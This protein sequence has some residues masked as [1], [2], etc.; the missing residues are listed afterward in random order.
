VEAGGV[1]VVGRGARRLRRPQGHGAATL[2]AAEVDHALAALAGDLRLPPVAQ[3]PEQ[4]AVEREAALQVGDDEIE[5]VDQP[6]VKWL[7]TSKNVTVGGAGM[8]TA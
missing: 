4:P 3:R 7:W 1:A 6:P 2:L 5:V 8:P